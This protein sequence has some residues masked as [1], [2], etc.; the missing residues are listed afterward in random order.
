MHNINQTWPLARQNAITLLNI[1]KNLY[2]LAQN[3]NDSLHQQFLKSFSILFTQAFNFLHT[4]Y[5]DGGFVYGST[6][7]QKFIEFY[8]SISL[9]HFQQFI[10]GFNNYLLTPFIQP[11]LFPTL[12]Q[13]GLTTL[14]DCSQRYKGDS[15]KPLIIFVP[16]LINRG[17]IFD[18]TP[19]RSLISYLALIWGIESLLVNWNDPGYAESQ[20]TL[21]DYTYKYLV[22]LVNQV[23][24]L[25]PQ[26]SIVLV[27]Y[28]MGGVMVLNALE[29]CPSIKKLALFAVPGQAAE[30]VAAQQDVSP[31]KD[32]D[33]VIPGLLQQLYFQSLNPQA[34]LRKFSQFDDNR[35]DAA[36]HSSRQLFIAVED[37]LNACPALSCKVAH[38]MLGFDPLMGQ[39]S[40]LDN[41]DQSHNLSYKN[42]INTY[43]FASY[44]IMAFTPSRSDLIVTPQAI[45]AL[46][47]HVPQATINA[48]DLGHIGMIISDK[49][50]RQVWEPFA[51]W[52]NEA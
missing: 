24:A 23:T 41:D 6:L 49:A 4:R 25:F 42:L 31:N 30:K 35:F 1:H 38:E 10:N 47:R 51:H 37:W 20:Y 33:Y 43:D 50:L 44:S 48:T 34:I 21:A 26:R 7:A 2:S 22:P 32:I 27:G 17:H 28:C 18:M 14:Q 19:D 40:D 3:S 13:Q 11:E 36:N 15:H 45:Q 16:S 46:L 9:L 5:S 8:K 12:L 52:V 39:S 29:R